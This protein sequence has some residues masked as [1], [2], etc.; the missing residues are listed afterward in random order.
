MLRVRMQTI[1]YLKQGLDIRLNTRITEVDH[2][3]DDRIVLRAENG[4]TFTCRRA[5]VT[6]PISVLKDRDIHFNP[7]LPV[8]KRTAV[9][10]IRM[11]RA[12]KIILTFRER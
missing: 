8:S 12:M 1:D 2:S 5:V 9:E 10:G 3:S 6:V 7:E 11:E 4:Q